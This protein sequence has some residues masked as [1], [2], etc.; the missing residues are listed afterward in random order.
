LGS[1]SGVVVAPCVHCSA[2][3][4]LTKQH[5]KQNQMKQH[6]GVKNDYLKYIKQVEFIFS[7]YGNSPACITGFLR[8]HKICPG[9]DKALQNCQNQYISASVE[10]C[11][12]GTIKRY[13]IFKIN[14]SS[15]P[16]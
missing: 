5:L 14:I 8:G 11:V 7:N 3:V 10:R 4:A 2:S 16:L 1:D 9:N 6:L 13:T 12:Q 15:L